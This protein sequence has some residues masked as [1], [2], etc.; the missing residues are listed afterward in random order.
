M[1]EGQV[2][3]I[4]LKYGCNPHQVPAGVKVP[5]RSGFRVLSGRPSYINILA[6]PHS[7]LISPGSIFY[8][9]S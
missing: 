8:A 4:E 9:L 6:A 5:E 7:A 2:T 1:S 3:E